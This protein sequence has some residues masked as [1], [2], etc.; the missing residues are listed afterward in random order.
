MVD[1]AAGGLTRRQVLASGAL[2]SGALAGCGSR[3]AAASIEG[4]IVGAAHGLGH[5]LREGRVPAPSRTERAAAVIAGAGVAGL[6]AAWTFARASLRDFVVFELETTAG[7]N[8]RAGQTVVTPY[9]WGAHYLPLPGPEAR[10]VRALLADLGVIERF[11]RAGRPRYEERYLCHAPQERLYIHGRW[12]EGLFPHTGATGEDLRQHEAFGAEMARFRGWRDG[13]GRRA[14]AI[15]RAA[16][17]PGAFAELDRVSMAD[18]LAARGW[19]SPRLHWYVDYACR[20][21]F[22]TPLA[23]TSAWAGVHYYA[24]RDVDPE[25]G[26]VVLT[27]PEGNAWLTRRMAVA[28]GDRLRTGRLVV[29]VEPVRDG[30]TAVDVYE[31]RAERTVRV[32]AREV[33]LACPVFVAARIYRPWRERPPAFLS[34]FHYAPWL[35]AN[36]HVERAPRDGA[37]APLAWDNVLY[38]S[39][40]LGYVVATHQSL[41]THDGPSVLTYYLPLATGSPAE[42]RRA[43]LDAPWSTWRERVLRDLGRA[44]P[45]LASRVRRL[46]VMRY[47]HGM[48]RPEVGFVG[49]AALR[50]ASTALRGP[51]HLA[52]SDLS[53]F[54]LFEEAYEWGGRAARRALARMPGAND[55]TAEAGRPYGA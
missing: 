27:W 33:I 12:Q 50:A 23:A 34:A 10:G 8:A 19:T 18:F 38:E 28:A 24:S 54:S 40:S 55:L 51:V 14:F 32:L 37:G 29:N 1:P 46:D 31:P 30:V 42:A 35:V 7:G 26:D 11:D 13:A 17:A 49:G 47:G 15:P 22:G 44:H 43:L 41:R 36:L 52:H 6:A 20:D 48:V 16:G 21:D 3:S 4:G 39:D 45:D 9:P 5:L 2:L 53:G 25:H